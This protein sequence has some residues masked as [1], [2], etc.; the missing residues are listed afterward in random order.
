MTFEFKQAVDICDEDIEEMA[1]LTIDKEYNVNKA[2]DY[3]LAK[4]D[5]DIYYSSGY[6][7]N[8]LVKAVI[9]KKEELEAE[10]RIVHFTGYIKLP[11]KNEDEFYE[12]TSRELI[13]FADRE[14]IIF[15]GFGKEE[16]EEEED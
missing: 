2:I 4:Y 12:L 6:F 7:W 3:V 5:D 14:D 13:S 10:G 8:D 15:E 16:E 9:E 11:I 1:R